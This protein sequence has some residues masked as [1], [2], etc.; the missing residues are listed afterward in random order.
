M[1]WVVCVVA[2]K[3]AA[4]QRCKLPE[5]S[6]I[7]PS[8]TVVYCFSMGRRSS[9]VWWSLD[10]KLPCSS[11]NDRPPSPW[12]AY[13][14]QRTAWLG[15]GEGR[16]HT[17]TSMDTLHFVHRGLKSWCFRKLRNPGS[18]RLP[19]LSQQVLGGWSARP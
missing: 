17:R 7:S 8:P 5:C 16:S 4:L 19:G 11:V 3:M 15:C 13:T 1:I 12:A 6:V 9:C 2:R 18:F 14:W 10:G